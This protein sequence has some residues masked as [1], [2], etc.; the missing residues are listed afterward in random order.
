MHIM[1]IIDNALHPISEVQEHSLS[2]GQ[3]GPL[4]A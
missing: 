2:R 1:I 3:L 4:E